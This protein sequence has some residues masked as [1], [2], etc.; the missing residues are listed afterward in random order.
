VCVLSTL[1]GTQYTHHNLKHM[2]PQHCS[3]YNDVFLLINST[4]SVTSAR[5]SV[6]S[7]RMVQKDLNIL[8]A[9]VKGHAVH[10][11]LLFVVFVGSC[12][13]N[14]MKCVRICYI[15]SPTTF[16][17]SLRLCKGNNCR[18]LLSFILTDTPISLIK[19]ILSI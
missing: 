9:N 13:H 5:L 1:H 14:V 17:I 16:E 19:S 11:S 6:S 12:P 18:C 3:T 10:L 2:L 7:L 4:E 15:V 8:G